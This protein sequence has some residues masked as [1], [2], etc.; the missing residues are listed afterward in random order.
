[1]IYKISQLTIAMLISYEIAL[2][3]FFVVGFLY[4][5]YFGINSC[6][7]IYLPIITVYMLIAYNFL[8]T[9][10]ILNAHLRY[11]YYLPS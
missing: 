11:F 10:L 5:T 4:D 1:M 9:M 6:F 2:F 8:R 3:N 7:S